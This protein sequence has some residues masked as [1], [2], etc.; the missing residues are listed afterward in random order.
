MWK[1]STSTRPAMPALPTPARLTPVPRG[2]SP[3]HGTTAP[4]RDRDR[5]IR[6]ARRVTTV[7]LVTSCHDRFV[8]NVLDRPHP[9]PARAAAAR[10]DLIASIW[11]RGVFAA[12]WAVA[13]GIASM[14][15]LALVVWAADSKSTA[16]AGGAMRFAVQL[17]L[18]A[19]R[20]PLRIPAGGALTIPPVVLTVLV[21]LLV[22]RGAAILARTV[23]P[24]DMSG[25]GRIVAAVTA[26][27][28]VLATILAAVARSSSLRPS[29]GA[30]FICAGLIGGA[31]ATIGA[32][33]GAELVRPAWRS[34]PVRLRGALE[35]AGASGAVVVGAAT[36][37][38]IASLIAHVHG[39]GSAIGAFHG[40][41]GE[42]S[43]TLLSVLYLPNAVCFAVAYI[44]GPGFA[45]GSGTSV[46]YGGVHLG[47]VPAF[48]LLAAVPT[49]P[50]PW[51]IRVVLIAALVLAG[52]A[53]GLRIVR[54]AE[55]DI[56][57]QL[58]RALLTGAVFGTVA[59][60][61]VGFAG[62][63]GG[64]GRLGAVG[65]SPWQVGLITTAEISLVAATFVGVRH[66]ALELRRRRAGT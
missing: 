3:A 64:P 13:V 35:A 24:V 9:R 57:E 28:A 53:A 7:S 15:V 18:L 34:V 58:R 29:I 65:P 41:P 44:V 43:M 4:G 1:S 10:N 62:G 25:L 22:V 66:V 2:F 8:S 30:A 61:V 39:F 56:R 40:G 42:F 16:S 5:V 6:Y 46:A 31:A 23:N 11:L 27:Y 45:I 63:P 60:I 20:S 54:R 47:A 33:R 48:P 50:A 17:W 55:L 49:G 19:H 26:P 59:A 21:G 51:Q 37:L 36:L 38:A 14:I 32:V 12:G 52:V